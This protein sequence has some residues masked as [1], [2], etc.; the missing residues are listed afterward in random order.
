M[1]DLL[2]RAEMW[3]CEPSE[4]GR[5]PVVVLSRDAAIL[6][7]RRALVALCTTTVRGLTS[8]VAL[9]PGDDPVQRRSAVNLDL[10]ESVSV[11]CSSSGSVASATLG[12]ARCALRWLW[13]PTVDNAKSRLA[14]DHMP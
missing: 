6:R 12:C 11:G 4:I 8:E 2:H 13:R 7:L 10:V 5:R 9:E 1:T 14:H 3:W